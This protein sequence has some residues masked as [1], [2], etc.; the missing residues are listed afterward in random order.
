MSSQSDTRVW[1]KPSNESKF[2]VGDE[3]KLH[4]HSVSVQWKVPFGTKFIIEEVIS[5]GLPKRTRYKLK[6]AEFEV[7]E[8]ALRAVE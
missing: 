5:C 3:V 6:G 4:F 8:S 7:Y 2:R 1:S